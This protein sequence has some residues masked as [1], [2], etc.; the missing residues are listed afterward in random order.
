MLVTIVSDKDCTTTLNC[1][2]EMVHVSFLQVPIRVLNKVTTRKAA[3]KAQPAYVVNL[4]QTKLWTTLSVID[5]LSKHESVIWSHC[6][7]YLV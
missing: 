2:V 6:N 4:L 3:S 5:L 7:R 1:K